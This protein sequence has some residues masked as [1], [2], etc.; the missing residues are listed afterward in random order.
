[1][2]ACARAKVLVPYAWHPVVHRRVPRA[3]GS[4]RN[5]Q[6]IFC[7]STTSPS[8]RFKLHSKTQQFEC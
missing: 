6:F 5:M 8:G 1:M 4:S 7:L 2:H 3:H